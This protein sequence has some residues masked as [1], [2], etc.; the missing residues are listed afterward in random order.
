MMAETVR[1]RAVIS[2]RVQGVFFRAET[3]DTARRLGLDGWVM[4]RPDGAV[5]A[6]FEGGREAVQEAL[7]WS[8]TGPPAAR[9]GSVD[10]TSEEP[11]G[12]KGFK[13]RYS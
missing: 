12:E 2:G 8:R 13:V 10:V 9:V 7:D 11:T 5:E 3:R 6:V 1:A 4:N